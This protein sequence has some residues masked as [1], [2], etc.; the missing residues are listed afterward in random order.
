MDIDNDDRESVLKYNKVINEDDVFPLHI[1]RVVC[2]Q[3][4]I[5]K[6]KS[7]K[8]YVV[9]KYQTLL[10]DSKAGELYCLL[11]YNYFR[12]FSLGYLDRLSEL[13]CIQ[14]TLGYSLYQLGKV[15][16]N[17]QKVDKLPNK[18]FLP[19]VRDEINKNPLLQRFPSWVMTS[20]IIKPLEEFGLLE[21]QYKKINLRP[22]LNKVKKSKL[23]DKFVVVKW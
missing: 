6:K 3:I 7:K 18:V 13:E 20:R 8:F 17:Y 4:G 9:K 14:N 1:I 2:E 21:C 22:E 19:A 23:F 15:C 12:K 10:S 16:N 11:F 5:I